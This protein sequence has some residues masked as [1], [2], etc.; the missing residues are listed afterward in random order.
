MPLRGTERNVYDTIS[1][2]SSAALNSTSLQSLVQNKKRDNRRDETNGWTKFII[3]S[4]FFFSSS[5]A[6]RPMWHKWYHKRFCFVCMIQIIRHPAFRYGIW[7]RFSSCVNSF[8]IHKHN[9]S[10]FPFLVQCHFQPSWSKKEVI[11][12]YSVRTSVRDQHPLDV[13]LSIVVVVVPFCCWIKFE[14][15]KSLKMIYSPFPKWL[16]ITTVIGVIG[17]ANSCPNECQCRDAEV[18]CRRLP[19]NKIAQIPRTTRIL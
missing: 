15:V 14:M 4:S 1:I 9:I 3:I 2:F 11:F 17:Q 6:V 12:F 10:M 13:V 7:Q 8:S 18:V 16:L 19:T 5:F